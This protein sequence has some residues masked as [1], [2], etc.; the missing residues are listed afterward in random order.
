[1]ALKTRPV[2]GTVYTP[3]GKPAAGAKVLAKL[4]RFETDGGVV[5]P[6]HAQTVTDANGMY[7]LPLWPNE[8]GTGSSSYRVT[9]RSASP[10]DVSFTVVVPDGNGAL[11]MDPLID[12]PP[13]PP[14]DQAQEAI[15]KAQ[16]A[17]SQSVASAQV[18]SNK[19]AQAEAD[20]QAAAQAKAEAASAKDAAQQAKN[21][22]EAIATQF[23]DVEHA[24]GIAT[25]AASTASDKALE[26]AESAATAGTAAQ[27]KVDELKGKLA[28]PSKGAAMV[29]VSENRSVANEV[30]ET[31]TYGRYLAATGVNPTAALINAINDIPSGN[32]NGYGKGAKLRIPAGIYYLNMDEIELVANRQIVLQG[33][34][35]YNTHLVFPP[36]AG[37]A[38]KVTGGSRLVLEGMHITGYQGSGDFFAPGSVGIE[39]S[40]VIEARDCFVDGFENLLEWKGGYYHKFN[41]CRFGKA[42]RV[43]KNFNANNFNSNDCQYSELDYIG[44][45]AGGDGPIFFRGGSIEKIT[46]RAFSGAAGARPP[47]IMVGVYVENYPTAP[48]GNGLA[49]PFYTGADLFFGF[50]TITLLG[51]MV[52]TK[53]F[54][55]IVNNTGIPTRCI[56]SLGN[57]WLC[58]GLGDTDFIFY[59]P[60]L[61]AGDFNDTAIQR[62][63]GEPENAQI[64]YCSP[65][66]KASP[67]ATIYDPILNAYQ[68]PKPVEDEWTVPAALLNGWANAGTSTYHPFSYKKIGNRVCLRGYITGVDATSNAIFTMPSGHYT[69]RYTSLTSVAR[70][71]G[72]ATTA[73]ALRVLSNGNLVVDNANYAGAPGSGGLGPFA[74]DGLSFSVD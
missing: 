53:G 64:Q 34:G 26:A 70:G 45:F 62:A 12:R 5:V 49:K 29:V 35:K 36:Q 74:L 71:T 73:V 4:N 55:R 44:S 39:S 50:G 9:I 37:I 59:A 33:D 63:L 72:A 31:F 47:I 14:I 16:A 20:A 68:A 24:I 67:G 27:E 57:H 13:Y 52:S 32:I 56:T 69:S 17:A 38:I 40:A 58:Q 51:N 15:Q 66:I 61:L 1:M 8:R 7:T 18:S 11:S 19:A 30:L 41:N 23:G 10:Q 65:G 25:G 43:Y 60:S 28:D 22:T 54:A 2:S 3:D 42:Q 6:Y 48:A 21:D 46:T